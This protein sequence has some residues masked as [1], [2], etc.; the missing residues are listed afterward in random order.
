M[1]QN[2]LSKNQKKR[3][4]EQRK[5]LQL[6]SPAELCID[7]ETLKEY[8]KRAKALRKFHVK[9]EFSPEKQLVVK[10]GDLGTACWNHKHYGSDITT[11][12]YRSPEVLLGCSYGK[13]VD[14]FSCG[15]MFFELAT[16]EC[17]FNPPRQ[18]SVHRRNEEHLLLMS[19]TIGNIPRH[20]I[21]QGKYAHNYFSR[22]CEYRHHKPPFKSR[23]LI[24]LLQHYEYN[25]KEYIP[26][27]TPYKRRW[28]IINLPLP[29]RIH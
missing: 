23:S 3:L 17:L 28:K 11:R 2:I 9:K 19:R 16:G 20:M 24:E 1:H 7:L 22:T 29:L 10:V 18:P 5:K 12:Q 8:R 14:I 21:K 13:G 27:F 15:V 6:Q 25:K 26:F 4:K